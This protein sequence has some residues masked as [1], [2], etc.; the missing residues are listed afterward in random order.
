MQGFELVDYFVG[1]FGIV[2]ALHISGAFGHVLGILRP[3]FLFI[4]MSMVMY[5]LPA[6]VMDWFDGELTVLERRV[7]TFYILTN[8]LPFFVVITH[9]FFY[10]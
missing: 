1:V 10:A 3:L 9:H 5:Y 2:G 6:L 7:F 4:S 8:S